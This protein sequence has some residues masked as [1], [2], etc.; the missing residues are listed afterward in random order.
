[1]QKHRSTN[2]DFKEVVV[3]FELK[4]LYL[5]GMDG[6]I[7]S[8]RVLKEKEIAEFGEYRT[9]RLVLEAFRDDSPELSKNSRS[10]F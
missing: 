9:R 8:F 5:E 6:S 4:N 1:M 3:L 7:E 2:D 10:D